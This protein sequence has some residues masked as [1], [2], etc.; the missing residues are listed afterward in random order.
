MIENIKE[1]LKS[2]ITP[3]NGLE[4]YLYLKNLSKNGECEIKKLNAQDKL[5][6]TIQGKLETN[7]INKYC[8]ETSGYYPLEEYDDKRESLCVLS[9]DDYNG[10]QQIAGLEQSNNFYSQGDGNIK[11]FIYKYGT[12]ER[13]LILYENFYPVNLLKKDNTI[14][15]IV[16]QLNG[17]TQFKIVGDNVIKIFANIDIVIMGNCIITSNLKILESN[18]GFHEYIENV[19]KRTL[20]MIYKTDLLENTDKFQKYL[21]E[22]KVKKKIARIKNS[23]VLEL[24]KEVIIHRINND[25]YYKNKIKISNGKIVVNNKGDLNLVLKLFNDDILKSPITT[26][27]YDATSKVEMK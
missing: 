11:G 20:D 13:Y 16:E 14:M 23:K 6:D 26:S 22:Y 27:V 12:K 15:G 5:R 7:L 19:S 17:S 8:N 18:F 10:L 25:E 3:N 2:Y 4:I 1:K 24:D 21:E 9:A